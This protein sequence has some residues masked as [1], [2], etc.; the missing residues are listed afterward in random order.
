LKTGDGAF[1]QTL[2]ES[3]ALAKDLVEISKALGTPGPHHGHEPT[4][5][6]LGRPCLRSG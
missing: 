5:G 1:L 2:P 4:P 3:R 6:A